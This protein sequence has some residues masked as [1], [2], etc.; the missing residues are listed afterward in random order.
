MERKVGIGYITT[1]SFNGDTESFMLPVDESICGL[2]F[3]TSDFGNVFEEYPLLQEHFGNEK[4]VLVNSLTEADGYGLLNT[5][6][7]NGIP[8]YHITA[9]YNYV[10]TGDTPLYICFSDD[11]ESWSA[12]EKMQMESGGKLFQ[13][14]VWTSKYIWNVS[15]KKTASFAWDDTDANAKIEWGATYKEKGE[16][17]V[18]VTIDND[19]KTITKAVS[20]TVNMNNAVSWYNGNVTDISGY[21]AL[22][23][24]LE[25]PSNAPVE[26]GVCNGGYWNGNQSVSTLNTGETRLVITL[27]ELKYTNDPDEGENVAWKKGDALDL[28]KVGLIFIRTDFWTP[29][30]VI[31][32]KDFYL[33]KK[34]SD[35]KLA[36]TDLIGNLQSS[37]E[38]VSGKVGQTTIAPYPVSIIVCPNTALN[39]DSLSIPNLPDAT[40]LNC[41]KVSVCIVQDDTDDVRKMQNSNPNNAPVGCIGILMACLHLAYAEESIGY[42]AK[43]NL[44]KN[45]EF[46]MP[47]II[48]GAKELHIKDLQLGGSIASLR[49]YIM[50][51]EYK[52]KE[53]ETFFTSDPTC[54]DGD[55]N[56]I[57]KNRVIHKVRRAVHS[58][59]MPYLNSHQ[60]IGSTGGLDASANTIIT[61]DITDMVDKVLVNRETQRQINGC[62]VSI[63]KSNEI[64]DT[65]A[66]A[67][68]VNVGVVDTDQVINNEDYYMV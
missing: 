67:V 51:C 62:S 15:D 29:E 18:A 64:L 65:D 11:S 23:L 39:D 8:A 57:A 50:P 24:E 58:A 48:L 54:D 14:G 41:P 66:I 52:G 19:T 37:A 61:A 38:T 27:N 63:M 7:M 5:G 35:N 33:A 10:G 45:D 49:G 59:L 56:T 17:K 32:V 36:F 3:D 16:E 30:Q 55:Y 31:R 40:T 26:V 2:L 68:S 9:F 28:T 13:I 44:N 60:L 46:E 21:D 4:T 25:S 20:P 12:V 22:V 42:V 53:A 43:F 6:F 1:S 34:I 47:E